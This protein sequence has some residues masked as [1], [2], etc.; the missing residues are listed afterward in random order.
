MNLFYVSE[1]FWYITTFSMMDGWAVS[2]I[3][4]KVLGW[5]EKKISMQVLIIIIIICYY[6]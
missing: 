4:K 1:E 3:W 5:L 2:Y 6:Y